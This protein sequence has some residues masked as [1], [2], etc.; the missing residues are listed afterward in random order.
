MIGTEYEYYFSNC[1]GD[2]RKVG[3]Q[4]AEDFQ[5]HFWASEEFQEIR[6]RHL[7]ELLT[8]T[9]AI[10]VHIAEYILELSESE[11]PPQYQDEFELL[12]Q[13]KIDGVITTNWD[14]GLERLFNDFHVYSGQKE[15]LFSSVQSIGEIYKIHG[16]AGAPNSMVLTF[17][18]YAE[19]ESRNAYLAAKL[20]TIFVEHPLVFLGYRLADQNVQNIIQA[21]ASCLDSESVEKLRDRLIFVEWIPDLVESKFEPGFYQVGET[22]IPIHKLKLDSFLPLFE[23][24]AA[25]RRK[26]PAKL[27]RQLKEQVYELVQTQDPKGLMF[28]QDIDASTD[29]AKIEVV[30]GV[31]VADRLADRGYNAIKRVELLEDV[32]R[33]NQNFDALRVVDSVLSELTKGNAQVPIF[34]YLRK[35][36]A[37]DDSGRL[38]RTD[39]PDKLKAAVR[40]SYKRYRHPTTLPNSSSRSAEYDALGIMG[41][42][43][44]YGRDWLLSNYPVLSDSTLNPADLREFLDRNFDLLQST[45]GMQASKVSKL[46]CLLDAVEYRLS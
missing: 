13:A 6:A 26:F 16:S 9:S 43:N 7:N 3:S 4:L 2:L 45:N 12:K 42:A 18:D 17:E 46:I 23:V 8:P 19:F 11:V 15:L 36:G 31:G 39:L 5:K 29:I 33:D 10:K 25:G 14:L 40:T 34:K 37:L 20:L 44:K 24:L 28:V 41:C 32:V 22:Q 35:S 21:I 38:T 27:L 30:F 1:S